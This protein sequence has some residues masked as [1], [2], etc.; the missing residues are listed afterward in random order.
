MDW[1][2]AHGIVKEGKVK[3]MPEISNL[4]KDEI[5]VI[6][7]LDQLKTWYSGIMDILKKYEN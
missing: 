2:F 4:T 5:A 1:R 7:S 6:V 3:V